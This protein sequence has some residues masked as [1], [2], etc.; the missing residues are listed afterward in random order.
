[1]RRLRYIV[2]ISMA[3]KFIDGLECEV[4]A[5]VVEMLTNIYILRID[6]SKCFVSSR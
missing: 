6:E 1:M 3:I 2:R 4:D 5:L